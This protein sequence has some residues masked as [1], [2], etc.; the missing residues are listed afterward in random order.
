[1]CSEGGIS[2][3]IVFLNGDFKKIG[4]ILY[5]NHSVLA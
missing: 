5:D 1:M 3:K 2:L 4:A